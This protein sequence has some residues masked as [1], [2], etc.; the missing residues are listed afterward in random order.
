MNPQPLIGMPPHDVSKDIVAFLD[1]V[2]DGSQSA[3][4]LDR[5]R[6]Q[7][8]NAVPPAGHFA[9]PGHERGTGLKREPDRCGS[10]V[11]RPSEPR[12]RHAV[13]R[14]YSLV[15]KDS[16]DAARAQS[17]ERRSSGFALLDDQIA[18]DGAHSAE[19]PVE[20]AVVERAGDHENRSK[21]QPRCECTRLPIAVVRCEQYNSL[22]SLNGAQ[23]VVSPLGHH[24]VLE[25]IA[26][27]R[28]DL[29]AIERHAPE[30]F[31]DSRREPRCIG[32][33]CLAEVAPAEGPMAAID[34]EEKAT[35][36]GPERKDD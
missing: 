20:E 8:N 32:T 12:S 36:E 23:H 5:D 30:V 22:S 7:V 26:P 21:A 17:A 10:R 3:V 16:H 33:E 9:V 31:E 34:A 13:F 4:A 25:A 14:W 29:D 6:G 1:D 18:E 19:L 15:D 11:S 28:P 35:E 24:E 2:R 27:H